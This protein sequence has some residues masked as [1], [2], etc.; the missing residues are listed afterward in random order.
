MAADKRNTSVVVALI[1]SMTV[2]AQVL[3]WLESWMAPERLHW[4]GQTLL[5]AASATPVSEVELFLTA[6]PVD[7][8]AVGNEY[9][10]DSICVIES[11]DRVRWIPRGTVV[12]LIVVADGPDVLSDGLKAMLLRVL[13]NM[14]QAGPHAVPVAL[15]PECDPRLDSELP[16]TAHDLRA[17]LVRKGF[18]D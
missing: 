8:Q 12:R 6:A 17:L 3:L 5:T 10:P 11:A 13:D 4:E 18:I 1:V 2:G 9:A 16:P 14:H 7:V 15:A